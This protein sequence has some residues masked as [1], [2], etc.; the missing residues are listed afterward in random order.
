MYKFADEHN[1]TVVGGYHPTVGARGGYLMVLH[2]DF[3]LLAS[4]THFKG[5]GYSVLTPTLGLGVDRAV[6]YTCFSTLICLQRVS[7]QLQFK[8][9][10]PDGVYRTANEYQNADL[11]WALRGGGGGTFGVVLESTIL[12][13]PQLTLQV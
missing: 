12:A 10:T 13:T 4:L 1:V 7:Y 11:F 2:S 5:A 9:V 6:R 8:I 3:P